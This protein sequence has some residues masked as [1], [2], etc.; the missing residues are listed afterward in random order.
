MHHDPEIYPEPDKFEPE[1]FGDESRRKRE[2]E[3]FIPFGA[4][5]R[6]CVGMRF[7]LL[8][9]KT[10]LATILPNYQFVTCEKTVVS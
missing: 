7:A 4:G 6:G 5:P 10:C 1:R 9:I 3:S 2:N 8:V